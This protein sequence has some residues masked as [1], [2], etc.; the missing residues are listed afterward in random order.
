MKKKEL[1]LKP[2]WDYKDIMNYFGVKHT[3]A[4]TIKERAIKEFDGTVKFGTQFVKTDSVLALY[5]TSRKQELDTI[6]VLENDDEDIRM[7]YDEKELY[8]GIIQD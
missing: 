8:K 6:K 3:T 7:N 1:L 2:V 4:Y 5:G